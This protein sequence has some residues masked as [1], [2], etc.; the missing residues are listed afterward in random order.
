[1]ARETTVIDR[2]PNNLPDDLSAKIVNL[3]PGQVVRIK[4]NPLKFKK[5]KMISGTTD[6]MDVPKQNGMVSRAGNIGIASHW[7]V[8]WNGKRIP[9]GF[10]YGYDGSDTPIFRP[11]KFNFGSDLYLHGNN[12]E[13]NETYRLLQIH[14]QYRNRITGPPSPMWV[15]ELDIAEA[16]SA[17]EVERFLKDSEARTRVANLNQDELNILMSS[18]RYGIGFKNRPDAM[19]NST[20]A[21]GILIKEMSSKE[22]QSGMAKMIEN[23]EKVKR[24][25]NIHDALTNATIMIAGK[26]LVGIDGK[27]ICSFKEPHK[28]NSKEANHE[29]QAIWLYEKTKELPEIEETIAAFKAN[30]KR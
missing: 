11:L 30:R 15:C 18:A 26:D 6:N 4:L 21:R 7:D 10:F 19:D 12:P 13:H 16:A 5:V 24:I 9:C 3:V 1:M 25:A 23:M 29:E 22:G 27:V 8:L 28:S 17:S 2:S 20:V 14:P